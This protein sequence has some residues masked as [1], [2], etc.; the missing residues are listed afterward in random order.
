MK[1]EAIDQATMTNIKSQYR[2][3]VKDQSSAMLEYWT[4]KH[5]STATVDHLVLTLDEAGCKAQA[6]LVFGVTQVCSIVDSK[7]GRSSQDYGKKGIY[8]SN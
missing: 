4:R 6:Q 7:S 3:S 1:P 8:L 2:D 5:G